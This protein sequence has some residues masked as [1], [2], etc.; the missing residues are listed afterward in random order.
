MCCS[1]TQ[2]VRLGLLEIAASISIPKRPLSKYL[3]QG[4]EK[5]GKIFDIVTTLTALGV[6]DVVG[7]AASSE[8]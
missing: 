8:E 6:V 3:F 7:E 5:E 1:L 4:G 2:W